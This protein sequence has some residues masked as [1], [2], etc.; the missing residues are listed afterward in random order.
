MPRRRNINRGLKERRERRYR[1]RSRTHRFIPPKDSDFAHMGR[2]FANHVARHAERLNVPANRVDELTSAVAAFRDALCRSMHRSTAGPKAT[3]EKNDARKHAEKSIRAIARLLRGTA[4][5]VLNGFDRMQ[6][7]MPERPKRNKPV[8]CPLVAPVLRFVGSVGQY[9]VIQN[10]AGGWRHVLEYSNDFDNFS[11]ARPHGAARLELFVELVPIGQPIPAHPGERS[12]GKCWYL[13]SYTTS[14]F[15]V[16][17]PVLDDGT[18]VRIV[19][20]GR[21]AD[22]KG[23]FGPFSETC[24]ACVEGAAELLGMREAPM[25]GAKREQIRVTQV[26]GQIEGKVMFVGQRALPS[27]SAEASRLLPGAGARKVLESARPSEER[28]L[29]SMQG[30]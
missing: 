12:G 1:L 15:E 30:G 25:L 17:Y 24:V 10:Q 9:G 19:Y 8:K 21:W 4:E 2:T 6:L 26:V 5:E 27:V 11:S 13:R 29:P 3:S 28:L 20:W 14:R 23:G 22:A 7:N 16:D 18:P